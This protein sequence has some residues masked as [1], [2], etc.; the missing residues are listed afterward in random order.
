LPANLEGIFC[1][2]ELEIGN[3]SDFQGAY[4]EPFQPF[5]LGMADSFPPN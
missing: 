4:T 2:A 5:C 1:L 3:G